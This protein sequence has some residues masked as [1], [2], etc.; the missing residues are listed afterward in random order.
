MKRA[1]QILARP[2]VIIALTM[3]ANFAIPSVS[4]AAWDNDICFVDGYYVPCCSFCI[5]WCDCDE[6]LLLP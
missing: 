4:Q 2:W 5:I 3:L 1:L 6:E